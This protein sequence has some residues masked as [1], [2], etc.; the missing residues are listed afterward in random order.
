MDNITEEELS[1]QSAQFKIKCQQI[2]GNSN[3]ST[4]RN[5]INYAQLAEGT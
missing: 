4:G 5:N 2:N 3:C 1:R